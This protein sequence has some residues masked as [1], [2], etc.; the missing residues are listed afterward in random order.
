MPL[1]TTAKMNNL[2]AHAGSD[3]CKIASPKI[4][5][6]CRLKKPSRNDYSS[7]PKTV[8]KNSSVIFEFIQ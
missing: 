5:A 7:K 1:K 2:N 3:R 8:K 4:G 6:G